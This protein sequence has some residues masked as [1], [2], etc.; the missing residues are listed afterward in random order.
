MDEYPPSVI[1]LAFA[2]CVFAAWVIA[3]IFASL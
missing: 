1:L 3:S 2:L